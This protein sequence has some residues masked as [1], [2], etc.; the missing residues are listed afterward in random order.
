MDKKFL[1]QIDLW[2]FHMDIICNTTGVITRPCSSCGAGTTQK[3]TS[4]SWLPPCWRG[5]SV[6]AWL[7]S[8]GC[9]TLWAATTAP[10]GWA[11]VSVTTRRGMNGRP[12]PPWRPCDLELVRETWAPPHNHSALCS[13]DQLFASWCAQETQLFLY[14]IC[15]YTYIHTYII[16]WSARIM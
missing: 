12:W 14:A 15:L 8:T 1:Q 16:F 2:T 4:G 11:P 7:W 13:Y 9:S 3:R 10:T 5:A 6:W